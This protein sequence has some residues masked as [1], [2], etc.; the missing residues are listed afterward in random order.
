MP[1][2]GSPPTWAKN[3]ASKRNYSGEIGAPASYPPA[4][5][6]R[7]RRRRPASDSDSDSDSDDFDPE[8]PD[9]AGEEDD[10]VPGGLER[11]D[12]FVGV[13]TLRSPLPAAWVAGFS[14]SRASLPGSLCAVEDRDLH[15]QRLELPQRAR[16][17][18]ALRSERTVDCPWR[19]QALRRSSK[20]VTQSGQSGTVAGAVSVSRQ[21]GPRDA[22]CPR[23]Q[24]ACASPVAGRR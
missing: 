1:H 11:A 4:M 23:W 24:V 20:R 15:S 12:L 19:C 8:D 5:Q 9:A 7:V 2:R 16:V 10:D 18:T 14:I 3:R 17:A 21:L 22:R 6:M 13:L